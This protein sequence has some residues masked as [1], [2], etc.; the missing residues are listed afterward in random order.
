MAANMQAL[1]APLSLQQGWDGEL[2]TPPRPTGVQQLITRGEDSFSEDATL[3]HRYS[4]WAYIVLKSF[5]LNSLSLLNKH[6]KQCND[7]KSI[8]AKIESLNQ[9]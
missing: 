9:S 3:C 1:I 6:N 7:V 2:V 4:W 8:K 5:F